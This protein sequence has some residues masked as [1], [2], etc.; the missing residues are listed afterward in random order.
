MLRRARRDV[1][2][3]AFVR[4]AAREQRF[5]VFEQHDVAAGA[6]LGVVA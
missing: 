6:G 4:A 1:S 3:E 5:S 2:R